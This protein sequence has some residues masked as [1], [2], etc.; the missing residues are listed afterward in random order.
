[1]CSDRVCHQDSMPS[2]GKLSSRQ[3]SIGK[4]SVTSRNPVLPRR[5]DHCYLVATKPPDRRCSGQLATARRHRHSQTLE[6]PVSRMVLLAMVT[7]E[8]SE[9]SPKKLPTNT[10]SCWPTLVVLKTAGVSRIMK[11]Y[12]CQYPPAKHQ[13]LPEFWKSRPIMILSRTSTLSGGATV[14]PLTSR[15]QGDDRF[16]VHTR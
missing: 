16:S 4:L 2:A 12:M 13:H 7:G 14:V 15:C 5:C 8:F 9:N 6:I 1:M 11:I 3:S 10:A